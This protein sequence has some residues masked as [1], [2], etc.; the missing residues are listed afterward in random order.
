MSRRVGQNG[1]VFVKQKCKKGGCAH[2]KGFC[3]KYGRYWKDVSGQYTRQRVSV[4]LG[5]VTWTVAERKLR[6]HILAT[7]V[8]S[9]ETFNEVAGPL[10][11][12]SEQADWWLKEIRAGRILSK[13]KRTPMKSATISGYESAVAW[14]NGVIGDK[15]LAD[16]KN[17]VARELVSAM[18]T[19][20]LHLPTRQSSPIFRW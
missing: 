15:P 2:P 19:A 7:G 3:P 12:F 4:S 13:K 6:E 9:V 10:A 16:V 20:N 11:T 8:D 18:K 14:L 1:E 17:E 5:R